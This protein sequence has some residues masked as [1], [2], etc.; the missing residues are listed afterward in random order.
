MAGSYIHD[1]G[2]EI[3]QKDTSGEESKDDPIEYYIV[4]Q[5]V[6]FIYEE[7]RL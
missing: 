3:G 5:R 7:Q 6:T 2:M 1:K 4:L